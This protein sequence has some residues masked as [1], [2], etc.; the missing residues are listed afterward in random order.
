MLKG[1]HVEQNKREYTKGNRKHQIFGTLVS[2]V[3]FS[4][5]GLRLHLIFEILFYLSI[6]MLLRYIYIFIVRYFMGVQLFSELHV[7]SILIS[8]L[9]LCGVVAFIFWSYFDI[10]DTI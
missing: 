3:A 10:S 2:L 4:W 9:I 7:L 8:G 5:P 6:L 1:F